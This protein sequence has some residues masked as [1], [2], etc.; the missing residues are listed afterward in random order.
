M[1]DDTTTPYM[2]PIGCSDA[3]PVYAASTAPRAHP[4]ISCPVDGVHIHHG[5]TCYRDVLDLAV[6]ATRPCMLQAW[7]RSH[8]HHWCGMYRIPVV[9]GPHE[10]TYQT[11][12]C[13]CYTEYGVVAPVPYLV[14]DARPA[15][16]N[17]PHRL[18]T[19]AYVSW[20]GLRCT[21]CYTLPVY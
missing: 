3:T 11:P 8:H 7:P 6:R 18:A 12:L 1:D 5:Y 9:L 21:R 20:E 17:A 13:L 10:H 16:H 14:Y 19:Y 4:Y 2:C 15:K